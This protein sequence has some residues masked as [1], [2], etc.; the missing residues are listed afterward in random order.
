MGFMLALSPLVFLAYWIYREWWRCVECKSIMSAQ[1]M[2]QGGAGGNQDM[3]GYFKGDWDQ[4]NKNNDE[5]RM[6]ESKSKSFFCFSKI[7]SV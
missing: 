1:N 2:M 5:S 7:E 4:E 3:A 6:Q